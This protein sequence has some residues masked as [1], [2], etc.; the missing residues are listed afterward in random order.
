MPVFNKGQ[1]SQVSALARVEQA[2]QAYVELRNV[3]VSSEG[4]VPLASLLD[5]I[6]T[7]FSLGSYPTQVALFRNNLYLFEYSTTGGNTTLTPAIG[8]LSTIND[9]HG[10][11]A[12]TVV[13]F[14]N[15]STTYTNLAA[16]SDALKNALLFRAEMFQDIP[17]FLQ[18]DAISTYPH[19]IAM[20]AFYDDGSGYGVHPIVDAKNTSATDKTL[21]PIHIKAHS[22]TMLAF[23]GSDSFAGDLPLASTSTVPTVGTI[24]KQNTT[25][26]NASAYRCLNNSTNAAIANEPTF[27]GGIQTMADGIQ[28]EWVGYAVDVWHNRIRWSHPGQVDWWKPDLTNTPAQWLSGYSDISKD[29]EILDVFIFFNNVYVVTSKTTYQLQKFT[30]SSG[31]GLIDLR[32]DFRLRSSCGHVCVPTQKGVFFVSDD[33]LYVFNGQTI[34]HVGDNLDESLFSLEW[35]REQFGWSFFKLPGEAGPVMFGQH[36]PELDGVAWWFVYTTGTTT[37]TAG[38]IF[39]YETGGAS[40]FVS[41]SGKHWTPLIGDTAGI[42]E[43]DTTTQQSKLFRFGRRRG[44]SLP[45]LDSVKIATGYWQ[46]GKAE[47]DLNVLRIMHDFGVSSNS[48]FDGMTLNVNAYQSLTDAV[49]TTDSKTVASSNRH[50]DVRVQGK[51]IN[52]EITGTP[53]STA[54]STSPNY[55]VEDAL[56]EIGVDVVLGGTRR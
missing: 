26:A 3:I 56:K 49:V 23:G 13:T 50:T 43:F 39:N 2:P 48:V 5:P 17:V 53:N 20:S 21:Y 27:V 47:H 31:Y 25:A 8:Y 55:G 24:Y 51:Y 34:N 15:L 16:V 11:A 38:V 35:F 40:Y 9:S 33:G 30:N 36:I 12:S 44:A 7:P 52:V 22:T 18:P 54:L 46:D 28:W 10:S 19:R 42:V 14:P 1:G 32:L 41:P 4:V 6:G 45:G 29:E 37:N